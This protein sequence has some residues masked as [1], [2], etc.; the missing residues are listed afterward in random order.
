MTPCIPSFLYVTGKWQTFESLFSGKGKMRGSELQG[1]RLTKY[2]DAAAKPETLN[3][4]YFLN[5]EC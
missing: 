2:M 4:R 5:E 1:T 3:D